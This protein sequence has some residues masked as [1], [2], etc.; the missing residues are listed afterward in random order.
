[1]GFFAM[2]LPEPWCTGGFETHEGRGGEKACRAP[3]VQ[4][5]PR[6]LAGRTSAEAH[7]VGTTAPRLGAHCRR[8]VLTGLP[9]LGEAPFVSWPE[10]TGSGDVTSSP[11]ARE[12]GYAVTS[13]LSASCG[14]HTRKKGPPSCWLWGVHGIGSAARPSPKSTSRT[15]E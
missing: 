7:G 6:T 13:I 2:D 5:H 8:P 1:M 12:P 11:G 10:P 3:Q 4:R 14:P 15:A 9:H